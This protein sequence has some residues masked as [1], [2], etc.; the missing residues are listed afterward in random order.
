LLTA[1]IVEWIPDQR[2]MV[3]R[4]LGSL[5]YRLA[6]EYLRSHLYNFVWLFRRR[7]NKP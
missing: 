7:W 6:E 3:G 4:N 2:A 5:G 1:I